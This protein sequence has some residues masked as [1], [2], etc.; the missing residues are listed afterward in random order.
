MQTDTD[1]GGGQRALS[2]TE[3]HDTLR[4]I[5][6]TTGAVCP[7]TTNTLPII[8]ACAGKVARTA[9]HAGEIQGPIPEA[10]FEVTDQDPGETLMALLFLRPDG[11]PAAY[12]VHRRSDHELIAWWTSRDPKALR[13][14]LAE[15]D[16]EWPDARS[17]HASCTC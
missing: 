1:S 14:L 10:S 17:S 2:F 11:R 13:G 9:F 4:R 5:Y 15:L 6:S 16:A 8:A 12:S 3:V 7:V